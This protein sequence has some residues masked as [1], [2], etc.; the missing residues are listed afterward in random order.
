MVYPI[1][2]LNNEQDTTAIAYIDT[3]YPTPFY[4]KQVA[5]EDDKDM[6]LMA[7]W[8]MMT[9]ALLNQYNFGW[10]DGFVEGMEENLN[11]QELK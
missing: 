11:D 7:E 8:Y 10:E 4:V 5:N 1:L 2:L 3:D 9:C 6:E